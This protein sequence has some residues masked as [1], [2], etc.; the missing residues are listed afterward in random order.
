[1]VVVF[2]C[3]YCA[4]IVHDKLFPALKDLTFR[5]CAVDS[6]LHQHFGNGCDFCSLFS[7]YRT[8]FDAKM[9]K[10]KMKLHS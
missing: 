8:K 6:F 7:N 5:A 2:L 1:M 9:T 10:S 3:I 4:K